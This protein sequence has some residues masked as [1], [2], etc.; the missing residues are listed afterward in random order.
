MS[1]GLPYLEHTVFET[2]TYDAGHTP[3]VTSQQ[4]QSS[5]VVLQNVRKQARS[6]ASD[7]RTPAQEP[8]T[9]ITLL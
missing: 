6:Q 9:T 3:K 8:A 5:Y 1:T 4:H 2:A 7:P